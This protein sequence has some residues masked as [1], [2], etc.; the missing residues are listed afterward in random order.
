MRVV[1]T[2]TAGELI[3]RGIWKEFCLLRGI[4]EWAVAEGLMDSEYEF[5]LSKEVAERFE[6]IGD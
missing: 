4:D 1:V 3:D 5:S 6:L 2:I